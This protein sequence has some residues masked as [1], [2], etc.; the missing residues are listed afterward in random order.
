M[1]QTYAASQWV[2]MSME[3]SSLPIRNMAM[4]VE[5][6]RGMVSESAG[7]GLGLCP[8]PTNQ[9]RRFPESDPLAELDALPLDMIKIVHFKQIVGGESLPSV[10]DGDLDCHKM[11]DILDAK[12]YTGAAIMEIP[13]DAAVF[14][15][16][17]SSFK[18]L[19]S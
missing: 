13:S 17:E 8:D 4:L 18:Y 3:N 7:K 5:E 10:T 14:D 16:L 2:I 9:L 6:V 12:G 15:N 19:D 11:R 1:L